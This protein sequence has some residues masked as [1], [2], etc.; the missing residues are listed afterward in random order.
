[1]EHAL[2]TTLGRRCGSAAYLSDGYNLVT[3]ASRLFFSLSYYYEHNTTSSPTL[4]NVVV[5]DHTR[6]KL[7]LIYAI[8]H[9]GPLPRDLALYYALIPHPLP[10]YIPN[11]LLF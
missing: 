6:S 11:M 5:V 9:D 4:I 10:T 1:M 2:S 3:S 7:A 8:L